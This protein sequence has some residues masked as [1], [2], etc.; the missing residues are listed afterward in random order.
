MQNRYN[1]LTKI[2]HIVSSY[3]SVYDNLRLGL[4][5]NETMHDN[6]MLL[7]TNAAL[8]LILLQGIGTLFLYIVPTHEYRKRNQI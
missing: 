7:I 2:R 8:V 5:R 6:I 4:E 1:K 3:V